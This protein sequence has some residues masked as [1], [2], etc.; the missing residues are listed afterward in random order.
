ML[1]MESNM[2]FLVDKGRGLVCQRRRK[3]SSRL[4]GS[5]EAAVRI[6]AKSWRKIWGS[7]FMMN[8]LSHVGAGE[9][10]I[11]EIFASGGAEGEQ[12]AHSSGLLNS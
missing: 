3:L 10:G 9:D 12:Q 2:H 1:K 7:V 4:R 8:I 11:K 5:M 6:R